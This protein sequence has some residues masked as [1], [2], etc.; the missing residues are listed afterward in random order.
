MPFLVPKPTK[1]RYNGFM[2][3]LTIQIGKVKKVDYRGKPVETGF[4]KEQVK[5]PIKLLLLKLEG[6]EQ[7]DLKVHGGLDKALY[8]YP[9]DSYAEW[10]KLRPEHSYEPGAFGENLCMET[11]DER[12]IYIGS[13]YRLGEAEI[14]VTQPRFPCFKLG[15]KFNDPSMIKSFMS[16]G[17]PG[18]YFRVLKEGM[19]KEGDVLELIEQDQIRFSVTEFIEL[20]L[21]DKK[22]IQ[23]VKEILTIPSLN[24][25]WRA[26]FE[27][28]L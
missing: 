24:H 16:F 9:Y 22:D 28:M 15:I 5:G 27:R 10:K 26:Q 18:V 20:Y 8:A 21:S 14:Q 25:E 17:R 23:R 6:D 11:L 19:I 12:T 3:I 13:I 2:K 7:A 1:K 4:F